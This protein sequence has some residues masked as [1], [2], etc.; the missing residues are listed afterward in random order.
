MIRQIT[1]ASPSFDHSTKIA[2]INASFPGH[3]NQNAG[4]KSRSTSA[5]QSIACTTKPKKEPKTF[6]PSKPCFYCG[7]LGHWVPNCEI[8]QKTLKI[9]AQSTAANASVA[10][11][12]AGPSLESLEALLDSGATHSVLESDKSD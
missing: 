1:T 10:S 12:D 7:E 4:Q 3:K 11:F 2:R 5:P 8:R 9:R 6:D